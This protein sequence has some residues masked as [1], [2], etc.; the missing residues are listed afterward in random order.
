MSR[1]AQLTLKNPTLRR[2][3]ITVRAEGSIFHARVVA[4]DSD[5]RLAVPPGALEVLVEQL[6]PD[7]PLPV[8]HRIE[9]VAGESSELR[10]GS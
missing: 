6:G 10:V 4:A 7:A 5:Q 2:A 9:A 1:A 3:R 8:E